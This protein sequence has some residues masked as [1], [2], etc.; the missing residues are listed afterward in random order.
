[1]K[2]F[3]PNEEDSTCSSIFERAF[4][5]SDTEIDDSSWFTFTSGGRL[6]FKVE[7]F[8]LSNSTVAH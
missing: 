3:S 2:L 6:K 1:M 7:S 5:F 8:F 4:N